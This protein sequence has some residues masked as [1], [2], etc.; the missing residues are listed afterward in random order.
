M[1]WYTVRLCNHV[2]AATGASVKRVAIVGPTASGKTAVAISLARTLNGE[3]ISADSMQIWR[4]MDIG[5]AK[6]DVVDRQA[7]PFHLLDQVDIT[8]RYSVASFQRAAIAAAR[9]IVARGR[10]PLL[11]GGTGLYIRA[12]VDEIDFPPE[13]PSEVRRGLMN[14]ARQSAPGEML[15]RLRGVDPETASRL[16]AADTKRIIRAL[17]VFQVTGRTLSSYIQQDRANRRPTEWRMFGLKLSP[18]TLAERIDRRVDR[19]LEQ[20]LL[21]E[22]RALLEHGLH[23][24]LQSCTALGYQEMVDCVRGR[25]SLQEAIGLIKANTRRYAKRQRTWFRAD[26]RITWIDAENAGPEEIAQQ[27]RAQI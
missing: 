20:G 23:R 11:A 18:E 5:T 27:I 4:G 3:I 19:M 9:D 17:E 6:P 26:K 14:E 12:V 2:L 1:A 24:G 22:V 10:A 8:E 21:D 15:E 7:V 16:S 13:A 25:I